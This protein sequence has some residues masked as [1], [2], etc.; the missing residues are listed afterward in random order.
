MAISLRSFV[1]EEK[2]QSNRN[3]VT[4][5]VMLQYF[6][7]YNRVTQPLT[8]LRFSRLHNSRR[9]RTSRAE[10]QIMRACSRAKNPQV[11]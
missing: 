8:G 6:Y 5:S 3:S 4:I 1:A 9:R 10:A 7:H 11:Q 2:N